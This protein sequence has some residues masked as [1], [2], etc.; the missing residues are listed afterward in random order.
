MR[1]A[2]VGFLVLGLLTGGCGDDPPATAPSTSTTT[3]ITEV[4]VGTLNVRGSSFY[5]FSVLTAG[6]VSVMLAS[7]T[8]AQPGP[9][10][11]IP[12]SI[13]V[14]VPEGEGCNTTTTMVVGPALTSQIS[15]QYTPGVYC[16]NVADVGNLKSPVSFAVRIVHP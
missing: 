2:T 8:L 3:K 10:A 12:V 15:A 9:T 7:I 11:D 6:T 16:A 4:F 13:G 14:G 1:F 5:S